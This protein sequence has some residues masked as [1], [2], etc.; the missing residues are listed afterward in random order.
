MHGS[1]SLKINT[2]VFGDV[3]SFTGFKD[4]CR[5]PAANFIMMGLA[6]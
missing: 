2:R 6:L 5:V 4:F 1:I 3:G